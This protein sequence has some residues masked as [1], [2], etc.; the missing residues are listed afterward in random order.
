MDF[1]AP[2]HTPADLALD[3]RLAFQLAPVGLIL[4]RQRHIVDCNERV[5]EIFGAPREQLVGQSFR[6]LYPSAAEYERTGARITPILNAHGV[7]ADNRVMRRLGGA[8]GT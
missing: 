8:R 2:P 3:Y 4:S 7:Y 1:P 5:C 6:L